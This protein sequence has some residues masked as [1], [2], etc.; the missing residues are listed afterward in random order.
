MHSRRLT[1][2]TVIK[3][4]LKKEEPKLTK[5]N[6]LYLDEQKEEAIK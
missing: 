3:Y 1:V 2:N 5:T 4:I 6:F